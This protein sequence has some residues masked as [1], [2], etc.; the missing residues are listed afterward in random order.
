MCISAKEGHVLINNLKALPSLV[1]RH[2]RCQGCWKI[3]G[4]EESNW[5]LWKIFGVKVYCIAV[6]KRQDEHME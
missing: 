1:R 5:P 6:M 3:L 4:M 2:G